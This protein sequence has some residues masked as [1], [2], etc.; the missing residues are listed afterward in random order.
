MPE[1][2]GRGEETH[3]AGEARMATRRGAKITAPPTEAGDEPLTQKDMKNKGQ[4]RTQWQ[5]AS[6]YESSPDLSQDI[7]RRRDFLCL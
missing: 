1:R 4:G 5:S 6:P 7:A 3:H 2:C